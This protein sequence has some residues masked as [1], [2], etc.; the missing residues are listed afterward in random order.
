MNP[1]FPW[2]MISN[3]YF[4]EGDNTAAGDLS[5]LVEPYHLHANEQF[6]MSQSCK[7]WSVFK[8]LEHR[9]GT[10]LSTAPPPLSFYVVCV[11]KATLELHPSVKRVFHTPSG[12]LFYLFFLQP[13]TRVFACS[14]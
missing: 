2:F 8:L 7:L 3:K 1:F 10:L 14:G 6:N 13:F 5:I 4:Q 9:L 12:T 11:L